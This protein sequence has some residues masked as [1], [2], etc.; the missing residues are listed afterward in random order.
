MQIRYPPAHME[1]YSVPKDFFKEELSLELTDMTDMREGTVSLDDNFGRDAGGLNS[2]YLPLWQHFIRN[3]W[4]ELYDTRN[5]A[6]R[7][8][9]LSEEDLL[10]GTVSLGEADGVI[11]QVF[12]DLL[13]E[14]E[15][16]DQTFNYT[17]ENNNSISS[18]LLN[19]YGED[20]KNFYLDINGV[21]IFP[22]QQR[23]EIW[24]SFLRTSEVGQKRYNIFVW[25]WTKLLTT[26]QKIQLGTLNK[27]VAQRWMNKA[28][29]KAIEEMQ[30]IKDGF[31][32]QR[33]GEDYGRIHK[34]QVLNQ[35]IDIVR[36]ERSSVQRRSSAKS[37][38][39]GAYQQKVSETNNFLKTVFE[40]L[41]SALRSILK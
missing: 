17:D 20:A 7:G 9:G 21:E 23:L 28:Q 1:S 27:A 4:P 34:N 40:Q 11:R 37:Q 16:N 32:M 5:L 19:N 41:E 8:N 6:R 14:F 10:D 22:P 39:S 36:G 38:E 25:I 26:F 2:D 18:F 24:E 15:G 12:E 31:Q 29:L 13:D 30:E 35:E 3:Y 33:S